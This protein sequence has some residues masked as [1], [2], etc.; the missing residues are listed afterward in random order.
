MSGIKVRVDCDDCGGDD[1][2]GDSDGDSGGGGE[3]FRW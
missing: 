2:G 1:G 3:S